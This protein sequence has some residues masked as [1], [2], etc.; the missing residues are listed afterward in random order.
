MD[1]WTILGIVATCITV[2]LGIRY[3]SIRVREEAL[4]NQRY[5]RSAGGSSVSGAG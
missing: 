1:L 2:L 3:A 4:K 5:Y